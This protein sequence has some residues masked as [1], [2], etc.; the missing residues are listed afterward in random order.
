MRNTALILASLSLLP[1]LVAQGNGQTT[2]AGRDVAAMS[3]RSFRRLTVSGEE[4]EKNVKRLTKSM[5]WHKTL[6]GTLAAARAKGKPAVW[7]QALGD[8]EGFL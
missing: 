1:P 6:S 8:L 3:N 4:V 5:R 7:I 2:T